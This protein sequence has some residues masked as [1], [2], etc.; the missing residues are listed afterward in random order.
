[1]PLV[2]MVKLDQQGQWKKAR[3]GR[4]P[5][6]GRQHKCPREKVVYAKP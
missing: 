6:Y 3:E 5:G 1:M 2:A 4:L